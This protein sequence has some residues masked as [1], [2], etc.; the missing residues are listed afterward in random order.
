M[1]DFERLTIEARMIRYRYGPWDHR[2]RR[3]LNVLVAR[4]LA[5]VRT[6]GRTIQIDLTPQGSEVADKLIA[7]PGFSRVY[8]RAV[9]LSKHLNLKARALMEFIYEQFPELTSLEFNE[10]ILFTG[11]AR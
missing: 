8:D 3:F 7:S 1:D 2:Y 10:G 5:V 4:R 11:E 9:L 6:D